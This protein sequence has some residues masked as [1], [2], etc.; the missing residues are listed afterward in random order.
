[1]NKPVE[2]RKRQAAGWE[3]QPAP[4][5]RVTFNLQPSTFNLS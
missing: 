3:H 5:L 2:A 4:R 1:M